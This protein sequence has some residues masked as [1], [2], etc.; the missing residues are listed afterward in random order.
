MP[1]VRLEPATPRSGV[2][3]STTE[4]LLDL[5]LSLGITSDLIK[6]KYKLK[7]G[8]KHFGSKFSTCICLS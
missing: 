3:H 1:P 8:V 7:L 2:N 5:R 4:P 6:K